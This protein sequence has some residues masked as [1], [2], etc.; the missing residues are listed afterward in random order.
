MS[1][2]LTCSKS[3]FTII[4]ILGISYCYLPHTVRTLR[5]GKVV[6]GLHPVN[7]QDQILT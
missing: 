4:M 6:I 1:G 5:L 2:I 7:D 3:W